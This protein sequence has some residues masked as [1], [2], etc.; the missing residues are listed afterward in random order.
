MKTRNLLY[1]LLVFGSVLIASFVLYPTGSPGGKTGSPGDGSANCTECHA[2]T[3]QQA[4]GWITST[5]PASGY[6]PG[7]TYTITATGM[8]EGVVKFGFEVT[9]EDASHA[10]KGTII[11]TD[12]VQTQKVNS[13]GSI[14]HTSDG[15]MPSGDSKSWSFDWTA[16]AVG[17]GTVTFYGAFNAANGNGN[18]T[19]DVIY[20]TSTPF[21]EFS[22]G[23][24]EENDKLAEIK[25]YPN[26]FTDHLNVELGRLEEARE[27]RLVSSTGAVVFSDNVS[28]QDLQIYRISTGEL[29]K[30][31]YH[32]SVLLEN[33]K[34]A[35]YQLIR[36]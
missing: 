8:H 28:G 27:I 36:K 24:G 25:A 16:P 22:T 11:V 7:Q 15:T 6:M 9:A 20:I 19:G 5:I 31:V 3:A 12:A 21:G 33:G 26:P 18:N 10:K 30:G 17:T 23:L 29:S 32:L 2:G 13:N 35:G 4:S 1:T 34:Q 14:T